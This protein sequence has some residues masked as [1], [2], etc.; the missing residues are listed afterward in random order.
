MHQ[1]APALG[2]I[3][4]S[5]QSCWERRARCEQHAAEEPLQAASSRSR[6]APRI[7]SE[8][9]WKTG[10]ELLSVWPSLLDPGF[11][12]FLTLR[13]PAPT[14]CPVR[15]SLQAGPLASARQ[16]EPGQPGG[17]E[18]LCSSNCKRS[19]QRQ[20]GTQQESQRQLLFQAHIFWCLL[21]FSF[22]AMSPL[23][24][25]FSCEGGN[26]AAEPLFVVPAVQAVAQISTL[27]LRCGRPSVWPGH[28]PLRDVYSPDHID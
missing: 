24:F 9:G 18:P 26:Y 14:S 3:W 6:A 25:F 15:R 17:K 27:P 19:P 7:V 23:L 1:L 10:R 20:T 5:H 13:G 28:P 16:G 22:L 4:R 8:Q 21:F 2:V 11:Q 12:P